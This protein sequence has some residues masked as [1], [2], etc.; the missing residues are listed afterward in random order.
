MS[1]LQAMASS[2]LLRCAPVPLARRARTRPA[3]VPSECTPPPNPR[4][5]PSNEV[6]TTA[7]AARSLLRAGTAAE[8][9]CLDR[10]RRNSGCCVRG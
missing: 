4:H 6:L 1:Q 2:K 10:W 8:G 9:Q 5:Q 3:A 7:H